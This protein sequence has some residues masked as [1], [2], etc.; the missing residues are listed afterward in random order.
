MKTTFEN[1]LNE[2]KNIWYH[3]SSKKFSQFKLKKGTLYDLDYIS[4][5][6]L[7]SDKGFAMYHAG[8]KTP[9]LYTVEVKTDNI[10]D[11]RKLP[12]SFNLYL[13]FEKNQKKADFT[14]LYYKKGNNLLNYIENLYPDRNTDSMYN[15]LLSGDYSSIEHTWVYNWLKMNNYDGCYIIESGVLNLLV[16]D[17]SAIEILSTELI[18]K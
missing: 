7:T 17:K 2:N 14:E 11:F 8:Y 18:K 5:I 15:D 3:G 9:Y 13:F 6:F 12:S 4:P 16:F 10:F 1:F